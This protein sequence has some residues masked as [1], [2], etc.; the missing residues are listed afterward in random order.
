[1]P[2]L[3]LI[4]WK[5]Q[6][7]KNLHS[8]HLQLQSKLLRIFF[9]K[10]VSWKTPGFQDFELFGTPTDNISKA[11]RTLEKKHFWRRL[12]WLILKWLLS[13]GFFILYKIRYLNLDKVLLF[14]SNQVICLKNRKFWQ[15]PITI[16]FKFFY[17]NLVHVLNN[18]YKRMFEIF[19]FCLGL[20]LLIKMEKKLVLAI[21]YKPGIF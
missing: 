8:L 11:T 18:F 17:W 1:M 3:S 2:Y 6:R 21:M 14:S 16:V 13:T 7:L 5:P 19:L 15:A 12:P 4:V 10:R 9:F 20:Q